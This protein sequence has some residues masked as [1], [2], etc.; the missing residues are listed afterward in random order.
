VQKCLLAKELGLSQVK[1]PNKDIRN[2]EGPIVTF[3]QS[4][5]RRHLYSY[6]RDE[7]VFLFTEGAFDYR[8]PW[9]NSCLG[10]HLAEGA[11]EKRQ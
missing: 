1:D 3:G 5:A 6:T 9:K 8:H 11:R 7:R 2:L 10:H 4:E